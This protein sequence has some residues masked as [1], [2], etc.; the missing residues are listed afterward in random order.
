MLLWATAAFMKRRSRMAEV[1]A[2]VPTAAPAACRMKSRRLYLEKDCWSINLLL[3]SIIGGTGDQMKDGAHAIHHFLRRGSGVGQGG[4]VTVNL[5]AR[6]V[7]KL[8]SA[9]Q[10]THLSDQVA[11]FRVRGKVW[12]QPRL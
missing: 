2:A 5:I 3:D 12:C 11:Q 4:G 7:G 1:M 8:A 6:S 9:K 10:R